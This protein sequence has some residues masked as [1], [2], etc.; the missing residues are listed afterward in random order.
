MLENDFSNSIENKKI[1]NKYKVGIVVNNDPKAIAK[2]VKDLINRDVSTFIKACT[3]AS[4]EY[5]WEAQ[6]NQIL[7]L[8]N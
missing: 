4:L 7:K 5:N 1:I 6:E 2:G 8:L 3:D